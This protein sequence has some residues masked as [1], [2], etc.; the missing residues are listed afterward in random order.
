MEPETTGDNTSTSR[1]C[2]L[3]K[4]DSLNA[5][6]YTHTQFDKAK[7]NLQVI[8]R[9]ITVDDRYNSRRFSFIFG[10]PLSQSVTTESV[11]L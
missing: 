7:Y 11:S 8:A 3:P 1:H 6:S 10:L 2:I 9:H 4:G 5:W